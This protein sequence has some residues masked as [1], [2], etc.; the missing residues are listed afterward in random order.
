MLGQGASVS[1][2]TPFYPLYLIHHIFL[3]FKTIN[4]INISGTSKFFLTVRWEGIL[5][6]FEN[7]ISWK[8]NR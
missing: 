6:R 1:G 8:W 2:T 3:I 5:G 7:K 4:K